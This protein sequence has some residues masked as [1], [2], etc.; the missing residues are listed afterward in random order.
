MAGP[1]EPPPRASKNY[2]LLKSYNFIYIYISYAFSF[3]SLVCA[4]K[5]KGTISEFYFN[6]DIISLFGNRSRKS[7]HG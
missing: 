3:I 6:L 1:N 2:L 5:P 7:G 4:Y